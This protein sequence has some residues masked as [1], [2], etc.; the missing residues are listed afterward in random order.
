[1]STST[2]SERNMSCND[3]ELEQ[4][5]KLTRTISWSS[6][7]SGT[8]DND[9]WMKG[10][11]EKEMGR[12]SRPRPLSRRAITS[13]EENAHYKALSSMIVP[14]EQTLVIALN[15]FP[16]PA[17]VVGNHIIL[18]QSSNDSLQESSGLARKDS[19]ERSGPPNHLAPGTPSSPALSPQC[20]TRVFLEDNMFKL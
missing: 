12:F 17:S 3:E 6:T 15:R 14:A 5:K 2:D 13:D 7:T 20:V 16:L 18:S 19:E 9:A 4:P 11:Y 1:M 8:S 10:F